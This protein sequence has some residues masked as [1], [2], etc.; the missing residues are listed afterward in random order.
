MIYV[1]CDQ[2]ADWEWNRDNLG[3]AISLSGVDGV[4][5]IY[6]GPDYSQNQKELAAMGV[7]KLFYADIK[8]ED[9]YLAYARLVQKICREEMPEMIVFPGSRL[10]RAVAATCSV[11]LE[12]GLVADC[13]DISR[14]EDGRLVFSRTALNSSVVAEIIGIN[15]QVMMCTTKQNV[16]PYEAQ[17]ENKGEQGPECICIDLSDVG[18]LEYTNYELLSS[19]ASEAFQ[20]N[21]LKADIVISIGRGVSPQS[22]EKLQKITSDSNDISIGCTRAVVEAGLLPKAVQIG[23]SGKVIAPKLLILM[24]VSGASQHLAGIMNAKRI[25]SIN[26]DEA[27][28]IAQ[29]CDVSIKADANE[30]IDLLCKQFERRQI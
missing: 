3:K 7:K 24:G 29:L 4:G 11:A 12:A 17:E 28:P 21:L 25:I 27:A 6:A 22:I 18:P 23:Q 13:I 15:H 8:C 30:V 26:N 16:F 14:D 19:E 9:S 20:T 5:C 1:F 2:D 10:G